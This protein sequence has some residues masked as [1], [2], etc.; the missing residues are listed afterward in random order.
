MGLG[1]PWKDRKNSPFSERPLAMAKGFVLGELGSQVA[2]LGLG[3]DGETA[4]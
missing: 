4:G 3:R 2:A 1:L